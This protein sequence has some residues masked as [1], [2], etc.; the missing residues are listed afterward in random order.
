M[1]IW[2]SNFAWKAHGIM[3]EFHPKNV[4]I[5]H[6]N[7]A[8]SVPNMSETP[9]SKSRAGKHSPNLFSTIFHFRQNSKICANPVVLPMDSELR[10]LRS[11]RVCHS[12]AQLKSGRNS[13]KIKPKSRLIGTQKH[14]SE[15][16]CEKAP[17]SLKNHA[18]MNSQRGPKLLPG[19]SGDQLGNHLGLPSAP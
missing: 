17:W 2:L 15:P 11:D 4:L 16:L 3:S 14:A 6:R 12:N 1:I 9:T 10:G 13:L 18:K 7:E 19:S 8:N 5:W